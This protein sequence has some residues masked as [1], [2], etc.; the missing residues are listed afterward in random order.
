MDAGAMFHARPIPRNRQRKDEC[1]QQ[2][3]ELVKNY[4]PI[5]RKPKVLGIRHTEMS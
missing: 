4:R 1:D 5:G 3:H 2:M